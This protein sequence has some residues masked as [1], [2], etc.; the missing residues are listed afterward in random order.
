MLANFDQAK[1]E[2]TDIKGEISRSKGYGGTYGDIDFLKSRALDL[3]REIYVDSDST[4]EH[5]KTVLESA[6]PEQVVSIID[7]ALRVSPPL[8]RALGSEDDGHTV[9]A[10][11]DA[12]VWRS[13]FVR[14]CGIGAMIAVIAMLGVLGVSV[15]GLNKQADQAR[16][17]FEETKQHADDVN[18]KLAD[19][20]V[21][22]Q[23]MTTAFET[24]RKE[25]SARID[26]VFNREGDVSTI[27]ARFEGELSKLAELQQKWTTRREDLAN[28]LDRHNSFLND[29]E[30]DILRRTKDFNQRVDAQIAAISS[31][32]GNVHSQEAGA[33][34]SAAAAK[35]AADDS[36]ESLKSVQGND[37][38]IQDIGDK[39]APAASSA[40]ASGNDI[41]RI[42]RDSLATQGRLAELEAGSKASK[43]K[44]DSAAKSA[45]E[46]QGNFQT[47][48]KG[49]RDA[50]EAAL[51]QIT[52]SLTSSRKTADDI[53]SLKTDVVS[54]IED[55]KTREQR[56][57]GDFD[58]LDLRLNG[59]VEIIKIV[60]DKRAEITQQLHALLDRAPALDI[61]AVWKIVWAT[62]ML[63]W[64]VIGALVVF[65]GMII[66]L[67]VLT[68]RI[69]R[70]SLVQ[71]SAP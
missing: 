61:A 50:A 67:V 66:W 9:Q 63:R 51:G 39:L 16:Q 49:Q 14:I 4:L 35:K 21:D 62:A 29:R 10:L 46:D 37:K 44:I 40:I 52:T 53:T 1:R 23:N 68:R 8:R 13:V 24:K 47:Y 11:V 55:L 60:D 36:A 58:R 18:K 6:A 27:V 34:S 41:E 22:L 2:L 59:A 57:K 12:A 43:D 15:A 30:G 17:F 3:L 70:V 38:K 65:L 25:I 64:L 71:P 54:T 20:L 56:L 7:R 28:N 42:H 45:A 33:T 19:G 31:A 48:L 26:Q 69:R 5:I 32:A